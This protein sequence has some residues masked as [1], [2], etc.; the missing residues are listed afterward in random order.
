MWRKEGLVSAYRHF[1]G[2]MGEMGAVVP[3]R[4]PGRAGAS[5]PVGAEA[6]LEAS[7]VLG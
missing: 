6:V 5:V 7:H 3:L 2:E 1:S 4:A